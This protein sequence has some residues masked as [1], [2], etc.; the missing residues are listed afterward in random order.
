MIP[1]TETSQ[2]NIETIEDRKIKPKTFSTYGIGEEFYLNK[3]PF[4][5]PGTKI[6]IHNKPGQQKNWDPHGVEGWLQ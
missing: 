3:T 6:I 5:H 2:N 4:A 1:P